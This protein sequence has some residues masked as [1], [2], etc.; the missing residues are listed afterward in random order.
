MIF[1]HKGRFYLADYKSTHLGD[2]FK[3]YE[4][5]ELKRNNEHQQY[6]LQYLIY[7]VAL[8]RYLTRQISGYI[9]EQHFGGVYYFYLRGMAA[10]NAQP[11]GVF[12]TAIDAELLESLDGAF[13]SPETGKQAEVVR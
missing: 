13:G 8:N 10:G 1:Q 4:F 11:L 6:D 3:D 2:D 12:Y 5:A 7:S 9:P